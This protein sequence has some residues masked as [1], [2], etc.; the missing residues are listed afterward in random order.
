[1][2]SIARSAFKG[3]SDF[4]RRHNNKMVNKEKRI[5]IIQVR[6]LH[7]F[8]IF[9]LMIAAAF[10]A[11]KLGSFVLTWEKLN[12]KKFVLINKPTYHAPRLEKMLKQFRG[13]ILTINFDK[14]QEKLLSLNEVKEVYLSRQLPSTVEI[15]FLLRKPIFQVA[16]NEKYNIIDVEGVVLYTSE[17][18]NEELIRIHDV[19]QEELEILAPYLPELSRIKD[20]IDYI[21]LKKP[22]GVALKLKGKS[23]I[24][25]PGE[26]DFAS[27]I[28][29]Y[30]KLR[31][32]PLLKDYI[33]KS[34]DL[35]FKDR[36][37]FEYDTEVNN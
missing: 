32:R 37:Y 14:L 31:Q 7:I 6:G 29:Y 1:M 36:F 5:R 12:V 9:V 20:S 24:F 34:V 23:E 26:T 17:K 15:K 28:N 4:L 27:K 8:V 10:G 22:Y 2:N 11:Y 16:F 35:R 19:K 13:N 30:L 21:S 33:V 18:S 3:E 25:Y